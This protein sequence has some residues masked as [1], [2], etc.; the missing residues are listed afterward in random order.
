MVYSKFLI[1]YSKLLMVYSKLLV[2]YSKLLMVYS[3]FLIVYSKS[4]IDYRLLGQMKVWVWLRPNWKLV[5][6][7]CASTSCCESTGKCT[8]L[9]N[10]YT[11]KK[12][13][14]VC[15]QSHFKPL[16]WGAEHPI[17]VVVS[18]DGQWRCLGSFCAFLRKW[19][20]VWGWS[21]GRCV[22]ACVCVCA[23]TDRVCM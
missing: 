16:W 1:V 17:M 19:P 14:G 23:S 10:H 2:D 13:T 8:V 9:C 15:M 11:A 5:V 12:Q 7:E 18:L 3:K 22:H 4:M 6:E 20:F 21:I